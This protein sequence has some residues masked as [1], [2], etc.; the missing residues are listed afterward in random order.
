MSLADLTEA[1]AHAEAALAVAKTNTAAAEAAQAEALANLN[2]AQKA[3]DDAVTA[4]RGDA[5]PD[6]AWKIQV[7]A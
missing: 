3:F 5:A 7:P 1:V 6:S 2:A 4:L